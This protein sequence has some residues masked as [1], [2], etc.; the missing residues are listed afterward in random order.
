MPQK[1]AR[2]FTEEELEQ[3]EA[4]GATSTVERMADFF[5]IGVTTFY[6]MLK[7]QPEAVERYKKGRARVE[8]KIGGTLIDKALS[9]NVPSLIFYAKTR[10]GW[11]ETIQTVNK[12]TNTNLSFTE[13]QLQA[14][15]KDELKKLAEINE[16]LIKAGVE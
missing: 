15:S 1:P 14:L 3:L 9:G 10:M 8:H 2:R 16:K 13:E 11:R 6:N 12:N 7:A 5:G 4:L